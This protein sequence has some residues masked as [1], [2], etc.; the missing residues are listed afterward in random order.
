MK[1][2]K[3]KRKRKEKKNHLYSFMGI[4]IVSENF[5]TI[6]LFTFNIFAIAFMVNV[7]LLFIIFLHKLQNDEMVLIL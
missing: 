5:F 7:K 6:I 4:I 2:C 3:I 1:M